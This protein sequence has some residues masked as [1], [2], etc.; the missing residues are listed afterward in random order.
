MFL[1]DEKCSN[2]LKSSGREFY[3]ST[4][5]LKKENLKTSVLKRPFTSV[6]SLVVIKFT[7]DKTLKSITFQ[8]LKEKTKIQYLFYILKVKVSVQQ[9][10]RDFLSQFS[11]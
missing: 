2:V 9:V 4:I 11:G 6:A 10:S 5:K 1:N 7:Y 8:F 3:R